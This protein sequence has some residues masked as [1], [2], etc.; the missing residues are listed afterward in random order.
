MR[1][2]LDTHVAV[3][4]VSKPGALPE[5]WRIALEDGANDIAVSVASLWEIAIKNSL[6]GKRESHFDVTFDQAVLAFDE[7]GFIVLPIGVASLRE[8]GRLPHLHR[9]PFDRLFVATSIADGWR[10]LTH[11][12]QLAAYGPTVILV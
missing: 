2:L 11:D 12:K 7:V 5:R 4:A 3:W 10:L 9:D 1:L 8:V 6:E